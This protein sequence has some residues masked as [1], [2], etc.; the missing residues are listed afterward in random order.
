MAAHR[1]RLTALTAALT[2]SIG[3]LAVAAPACV[4]SPTADLARLRRC[5]VERSPFRLEPQAIALSRL[6][7]ASRTMPE[8][9]FANG[10]LRTFTGQV[11]A[12]GSSPLERA[13]SFL[14]RYAVLYGLNDP[15]VTISA[16][17]V[18]PRG[19]GHVVHFDESY[20]NV[21]VLGAD[22]VVV[23]DGSN[24]FATTG[25]LLHHSR[26]DPVF[27]ITGMRAEQIAQRT[28]PVATQIISR[29]ELAIH[30]A[31]LGDAR[32]PSQAR[33][34]WQVTLVGSGRTRILVDAHT[35]A[36]VLTDDLTLLHDAGDP[37]DSF[38]EYELEME[39][40]FGAERGDLC[41]TWSNT[42]EIADEGGIFDPAYQNDVDANLAWNSSHQV[43]DFFHSRYGFDSYGDEGEEIETFIHTTDGGVAS[44]SSACED[45]SFGP[46]TPVLDVFGHE[47]THAIIAE[48][49]PDFDSPA[50]GQRDEYAALNEHYSDVFGAVIGGDWAIG[51][52]MPQGAVRDLSN[53][54]PDHYALYDSTPG[55]DNT[56]QHF[57]AGIMNR[58]AHL[59]SEGEQ[60]QAFPV[61]GM[62]PDKMA[63]LWWL[64]MYSLG[65]TSG[66]VDAA[67]MTMMTANGPFAGL[68]TD[69]DRC[70]ILNA[71]TTVGV[72]PFGDTNCDGTPEEVLDDPDLDSWDTSIDNCWQ[73]S[74]PSQANSDGDQFGDACDADDDNDGI[75][76]SADDCQFG[77]VCEDLDQDGI[78]NADDNCP[79]DGNAAQS[80]QDGD[81]MGDACDPDLDGDGALNDADNCPNHPNADQ[82]DS[83]NGGWGDV[84]DAMPFSPINEQVAHVDD[85]LSG[86]VSAKPGFI[87]TLRID[88]CSGGCPDDRLN[89]P[90]LT[91]NV[92]GSSAEVFVTD[93]RGRDQGR[94][95]TGRLG[96]SVTFR[97]E[98]GRSYA[99]HLAYSPMIDGVFTEEIG[100]SVTASHV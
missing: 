80:N 88:R 65:E 76:D 74:N 57:N 11:A 62:G 94:A 4:E 13:R 90:L 50:P 28:I 25:G 81:S 2:V 21:P 1:L 46:G 72:L 20:R 71:F 47:F 59:V 26:V 100:V 78:K 8:F 18:Q 60:Q 3:P 75:P 67:L 51:E 83:D 58:V 66:F 89:A 30:D 12:G 82:L 42:D 79:N 54:V 96:T 38:S 84:C 9:R 23:V 14:N 61:T 98:G 73:T 7:A 87:Q 37:F 64:S 36:I 92:F 91:V 16:A 49:G 63:L 27:T 77:G 53:P 6:R 68:F 15:S 52:D 17:R 55:G 48:E 86:V 29:T 22:L 33:L 70:D 97:P 39:E 85:I 35:G 24:V 32:R 34:V 99:V 45:F 31:A 40:A 69:Q 43:Y 10:T 95:I 41:F 44:F 56:E 19:T 5:V 93:E